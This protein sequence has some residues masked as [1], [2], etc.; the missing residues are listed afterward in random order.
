MKKIALISAILE[1]PHDTQME[2]NSIVSEYKDIIKGRMGLPFE[3]SDTAIIAISV[4]AEM[5]R[6]NSFTGRLGKVPNVIVKTAV[7]K[8]DVL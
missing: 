8:K 4:V 5:D 1:C 6:I 3:D 2:F 7:S